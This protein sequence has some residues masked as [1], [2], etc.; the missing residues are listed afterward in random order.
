MAAALPRMEAMASDA[1]ASLADVTG[2]PALRHALRVGALNT[3]TGFG[4]T[5]PPRPREN[6]SLTDDVIVTGT[7]AYPVL[8]LDAGD[9]DLVVSA[10][11]H[12]L[13]VAASPHV[14][15]LLERVNSGER[16]R[17]GALVEAHS[18]TVRVGGLE[19]ETTRDDVRALLEKLVSLR[20][21]TLP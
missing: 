16:L 11:G 20:A 6:V 13:Q 10:N 12:A 3:L 8:W 5:R 4:F 7:V 19:F 17:V 14:V 15:A 2:D 21:L 1:V 9:D 18:G